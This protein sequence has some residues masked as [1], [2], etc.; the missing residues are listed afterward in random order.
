MTAP[1]LVSKCPI[2]LVYRALTGVQPRRSGR[3]KWRGPAPWRGGRNPGAIA[4]D[5]SRGVWFDHVTGV[6]GGVLD[7]VQQVRRISR[8]HAV[9]FL[10]NL[11]GVAL[12]DRLPTRT[13]AWALAGRRRAAESTAEDIDHWRGALIPELDRDK[14][15]AIDAGNDDALERAASLQHRL[16]TGPPADIVR[17]YIRML[18]DDPAELGRLIEAGRTQALEAEVLTAQLVLM[19]ARPAVHIPNRSRADTHA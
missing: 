5:D 17:E 8:A 9:R 18:R 6:G 13:Q 1:E 19:L 12:E 10:A 4:L 14:L 16:T 3:D 11:A 15:A 2:S 7:L